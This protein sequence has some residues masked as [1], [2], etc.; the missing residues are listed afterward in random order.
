MSK[1]SIYFVFRYFY[2]IPNRLFFSTKST[3]ICPKW[4]SINQKMGLVGL[5]LVETETFATSQFAFVA[6]VVASFPFV[7]VVIV[8]VVATIVL[9]VVVTALVNVEFVVAFAFHVV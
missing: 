3:C 9:V 1:I 6:S 7:V 8:P 5:F 4:T 2:E